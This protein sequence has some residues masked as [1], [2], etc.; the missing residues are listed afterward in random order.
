LAQQIPPVKFTPV[1]LTIEELSKLWTVF[2]QTA[3]AL[4]ITFTASPVL[5]SPDVKVPDIPKTK[6]PVS[7]ETPDPQKAPGY[8]I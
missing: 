7:F 8:V 3:H 4:S 6:I 2:F 5:I 1:A